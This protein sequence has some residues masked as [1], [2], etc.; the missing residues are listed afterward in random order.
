MNKAKVREFLYD[1]MM[2]A[3]GLISIPIVLFIL[4]LLYELKI[5]GVF[6]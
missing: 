6:R 2:I 4:L 5:S 1:V 3:F